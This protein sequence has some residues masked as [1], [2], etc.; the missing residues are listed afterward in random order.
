MQSHILPLDFQ[1]KC[2]PRDYTRI[3]LMLTHTLSVSE[4]RHLDGY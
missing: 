1:F 3:F 2:S 4:R